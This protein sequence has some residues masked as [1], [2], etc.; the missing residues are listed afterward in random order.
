MANVF[1]LTINLSVA[2]VAM[3]NQSKMY[4]SKCASDLCN[5]VSFIATGGEDAD[6]GTECLL[7]EE[8][9]TAS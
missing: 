8:Q 5:Y 3:V 4:I 7:E 6:I 9:E 1:T 2:I